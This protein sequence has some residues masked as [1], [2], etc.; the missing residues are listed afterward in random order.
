MTKVA[1]R[2]GGG[3]GGCC[4]NFREESSVQSSLD[5][6]DGD[7]AVC[8]SPMGSFR[9]FFFLLFHKLLCVFVVFQG[10]RLLRLDGTVRTT[11]ERQRLID[12]FAVSREYSCFLLTTQVCWKVNK[13]LSKTR[14]EENKF[15]IFLSKIFVSWSSSKWE[16]CWIYSETWLLGRVRSIV[17]YDKTYGIFLRGFANICAVSNTV[18]QKNFISEKFRQKWPSGSSSG[19][20]F[21]QTSDRSFCLWSFGSLAAMLR[22]S[23]HS[24]L[25]LIP[26]L[27]F[28]GKFSQEFNLVKKLLWRKRRN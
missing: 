15:C 27:S 1:S 10:V 2:R 21:R 12:K 14:W 20:Y 13:N 16:R 4:C 5:M 28:C 7:T 17:N 3:G 23:S 8:K 24:W 11:V 26:H 18:Q 25:F 6:W 9:R 19:I 22:L